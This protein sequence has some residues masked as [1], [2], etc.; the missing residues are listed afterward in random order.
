[1]QIY[2]G[3]M[4]LLDY[5]FYA[6]VE[7]GK[8]YETGAFIHNYALTYALGLVRGETYTYAQLKQSPHYQA[9]LTP[10]NGQVYLTPGTPQRIAHRLVQWNTISE[11]YAFPGKAPSI[12]YPDWGF[13]RVLRP[14]CVFTLYLLVHDGV[15][16]PEAPALH[17][18]LAGRMARV[19]LGKFPGKARLCLEA[20]SRVTE[21]QG[22]FRADT[23]LNWRD[24]EVDPLVCDVL[25]T[26][27]PTRLIH[28]AHF[29]DGS[30]YE[31]HFGEDVVR[32]PVAMRFLAKLP[33]TSRSRRKSK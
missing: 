21:R 5:V 10:L 9:E 3:T 30:F 14:G 2:R 29:D 17:D 22:T 4:E 18:L 15:P 24:L 7:R 26:S 11:G 8:V 32:L 23:L 33:E 13:A 20:A 19:R 6:T 25:P 31:T 12:G 27:L 16:L 28:H 1:M